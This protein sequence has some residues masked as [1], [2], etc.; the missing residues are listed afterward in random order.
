MSDHRRPT[1][2]GR[3]GHALDVARVI[4]APPDAIFYAFIALYDSRR[5]EWVTD[6]RLDLRCGGRWSVA[7]QVPD[8]PA[9]SEERV[10][11]AL[12]C[13][14][15]LAYD[16]AAVFDDEAGFDTTV[17]VTI[18]AAEDGHRIRLMQRGFP[19]AATRDEFAAAWPDVLGELARRLS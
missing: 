6:S 7:F 5:P 9:F 12:E 8:G 19:T 11:T 2:G 1:E 17:E 18:E 3:A 16:M 15:R 4:D 13:P 10:I 14:H